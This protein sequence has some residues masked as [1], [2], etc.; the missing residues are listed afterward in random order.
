MSYTDNDVV[1]YYSGDSTYA[2]VGLSPNASGNLSILSSFTVNSVQYSVTSIGN[3]AFAYCS[4]LTSVTIPVDES[5]EA[6]C[7]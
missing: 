3:I 4:K 7:G 1:Y 2:S 6:N 5:M